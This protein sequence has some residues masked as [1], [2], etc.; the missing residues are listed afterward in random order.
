MNISPVDISALHAAI[1]SAMTSKLAGVTVDYAYNRPGE[2]LPVPAVYIDLESISPDKNQNFGTEQ[3][4]VVL[5]FSVEC[6]CAYKILSVT[7][8]GK[9]NVRTLA[10]TV[11]A[12]VE[13]NKWDLAT[14][15]KGIFKGSHPQGFQS[16]DKIYESWV[17]N[18][19]HCAALGSD[20]WNQL[21]STLTEGFASEAPRVGPAY[22]ADYEQLAP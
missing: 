10:A 9:L 12:L 22:L 20:L 18:W 6:I 13:G 15:T 2:K 5:N 4:G 3:L 17:V 19:Q 7:Q 1:K 11:S 8:S 16:D 21:G 14:V